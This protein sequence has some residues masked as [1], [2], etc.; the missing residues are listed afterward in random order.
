MLDRIKLVLGIEDNEQDDVLGVLVSYVESH[1]RSLLKEEVPAE[2]EY[3]VEEITIR[4]FNRIGA[5]GMKSES[6]EGH[7]VTFYS[8]K[9][10]FEP[11]M[12]I[13]NEYKDENHGRGR[14]M[15]I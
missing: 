1:L 5:E 3:I 8:L 2:L 12:D 13:I 11:Y 15:F 4:R 6:V 7:T 10:D 9:D 14:V